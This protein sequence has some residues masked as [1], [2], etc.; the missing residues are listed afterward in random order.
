M[1]PSIASQRNV[2]LPYWMSVWR[3]RTSSSRSLVNCGLMQ[4]LVGEAAD[5]RAI[6]G[7]QPQHEPLGRHLQ[8]IQVQRHAAARVE[9]GDDRDRL[10]VA[11][12]D[13]Q[14]AA[15]CRCRRSRSASARGRAPGVRCRPSRS[16]RSRPSATCCGTSCPAEAP[17]AA[18]SDAPTSRTRTAVNIRVIGHTGKADRSSLD[19]SVL[20]PVPVP[21]SRFDGTGRTRLERARTE[22]DR[23]RGTGTGNGN[24]S[25]TDRASVQ[26][27]GRP[28]ARCRGPRAP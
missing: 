26:S 20:V 16:R 25:M 8:E 10:D 2:G 1:L 14:A 27:S 17:A 13:R 9:H 12:E 4:N 5:A 7:Q 21:G 19:Y 15:A 23:E 22:R 18:T 11:L 6:L 3:M 28:C 24:A